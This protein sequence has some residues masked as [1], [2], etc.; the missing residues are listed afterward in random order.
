MG[1]TKTRSL[2]GSC[3]RLPISGP[4]SLVSRSHSTHRMGHDITVVLTP[5]LALIQGLCRIEERQ[6]R[7][8]RFD[9]DVR[10]EEIALGQNILGVGE[11]ELHE[12]YGGIGVR[13]TAGDAG[14]LE[15]RH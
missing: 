15:A 8:H 9:L 3:W 14:A 12:Q 6:T 1:R 11:H 13:R 5:F 7:R 10:R 4:L 2:S